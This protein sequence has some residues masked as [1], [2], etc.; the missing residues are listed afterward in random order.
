[1]EVKHIKVPSPLHTPVL[2]HSSLDGPSDPSGDLKR[3]SGMTNL[4]LKA[5]RNVQV[6]K[7]DRTSQ[8]EED[9]DNDK[10]K[11]EEGGGEGEGEKE[12]VDNCCSSS[13]I[14]QTA[15]DTDTQILDIDFMPQGEGEGEIEYGREVPSLSASHSSS[16]T[17]QPLPSSSSSS[18]STSTS[19]S[20]SDELQSDFAR[21][22][23]IRGKEV[24]SCTR[25]ITGNSPVACDTNY[26][27]AGGSDGAV[28]A[29]I[30]G[31]SATRD[32]ADTVGVEE[33]QKYVSAVHNISLSGVVQGALVSDGDVSEIDYMTPFTPPTRLKGSIAAGDNVMPLPL[34]GVST[35]LVPVPSA[36]T[37]IITDGSSG[38]TDVGTIKS[39]SGVEKVS[40][41]G[42]SSSTSGSCEGHHVKAVARIS[43]LGWGEHYDAWIDADS[44]LLSK[45]NSRSEGRRGDG[46][47]REEV[48]FLVRIRA[49]AAAAATGAELK[50]ECGSGSAANGKVS[51]YRFSTADSEEQGCFHSSDLADVVNAFGDGQG[52]ESLLTCM[53]SAAITEW[54]SAGEECKA[55]P[56]TPISVSSPLT[57]SIVTAIGG[58][59]RILSPQFLLYLDH[60]GFF[61]DA[62]AA[63]RNMSL[64][65]LRETPV[66]TVEVALD[67][68]ERLSTALSYVPPLLSSSTPS[69]T[70]SLDLAALLYDTAVRYLDCPYLNRRL[71]GLKML[72]DLFK[73]AQSSAA[74]PSGISVTRSTI[75]GGEE[76]VSYR[77]LPLLQHHTVRTLSQ[78]VAASSL[79]SSIFR[80]ERSHES[81]M[82][83]SWDILR[84]LIQEKCF[85]NP[86]LTTIW[87]AGFQQRETA[88]MTSLT[89]I[90]SVMGDTSI[91]SL[92]HSM[93]QVEPAA[94]TTHVVDVLSSMAMRC[95]SLVMAIPPMAATTDLTV[96]EFDCESA[97]GTGY[98]HTEVTGEAAETLDLHNR[99][100]HRLWAWAE[101]CSGVSD[102]AAVKCLSILVSAISLGTSFDLACADSAFPWN[103]QWSRSRALV[104][105]ALQSL[106][107]K[108]SVVPAVRLLQAFV[109]SLPVRGDF[110][111][112]CPLFEN[113]GVP[114][115]SPTRA[116][117]AEYLEATHG[118]VAAITSTICSFK[119]SFNNSVKSIA[120]DANGTVAGPGSSVPNS[121]VHSE[122]F[123]EELQAVLND[124]MVCGSRVGYKEQ[125]MRSLDFLHQFLRCSDS[126]V[127]G[128]DVVQSLWT[129]VASRAVTTEEVNLMVSFLTRL[130]LR[131]TSTSTSTS[132]P[133]IATLLPSELNTASSRISSL[134][135]PSCLPCT[136]MGDTGTSLPLPPLLPI[137]SAPPVPRRKAV[138]SLEVITW[139]FAELLCDKS[140]I[141]SP[142]FT[143][144]AFTCIEKYFKWLNTE[145]GLIVEAKTNT[146]TIVGPPSSLI[147]ISVFSDIII[148]SRWDPVASQAATLLTSL[149]S[150]L[151]PSLVDAGE[152]VSLRKLLLEQCTGQLAQA[153]LSGIEPRALSRL[154][155]LLS[156]LLDESC[157]DL[158]GRVQ[159]H[160]SLGQGA[161]VSLFIS[162]ANKMKELSGP[163]L[164]HAN[165]PLDGLFQEIC[166]RVNRPLCRLKVFRLA[167]DITLLDAQ[168][169]LGQ[170]KFGLNGTEQIMVTERAVA[171]AAVAPL[172]LLLPLTLPVAL[173]HDLIGESA[174]DVSATEDGVNTLIMSSDARTPVCT[175]TTASVSAGVPPS[176]SAILPTNSE[177]NVPVEMVV[178][179]VKELRVDM[180]PAMMLSS[181]PEHLDMMFALLEKSE[182][183]QV[184]EIWS[185]ISRLPS[186][187]ALM[188]SWQQL[189]THS[190]K[191]L[192]S[193]LS[194]PTSAR[195]QARAG[196]EGPSA[197]CV[198]R[199]LY[200]LQIIEAF[201]QPGGAATIIS[202]SSQDSCPADQKKNSEDQRFAPSALC[203]YDYLNRKLGH[204]WPALFLSKGGVE[205]ICSVYTSLSTFMAKMHS[206]QLTDSGLIRLG[207]SPGLVLQ[208][209]EVAVRLMRSVIVRGTVAAAVPDTNNAATT[210]ATIG[211]KGCNNS[212]S[213]SSNKRKLL[214]HMLRSFQAMRKVAPSTGPIPVAPTS[215]SSNN[216]PFVGPLPLPP[217]TSSS[218]SS[219][220]IYPSKAAD[221]NTV[222]IPAHTTSD[223]EE[224]TRCALSVPSFSLV[225]EELMDADKD[226]AECS[227][228]LSIEW[229][230]AMSSAT[231]TSS[232]ES[233]AASPVHLLAQF[234]QGVD[235]DIIQ[236]TSLSLMVSLRSFSN[237]MAFQE[238]SA[239]WVEKSTV[240]V[241]RRT[242]FTVLDSLFAVWA[243]AAVNKPEILLHLQATSYTPS[244]SSSATSASIFSE[245]SDASDMSL[246]LQL[247]LSQFL[248][249]VKS[250][251][252]D[253]SEMGDIIA[254]WGSEE[255]QIFIALISLLQPNNI[256][257]KSI[258]GLSASLKSNLFVSFLSL[259]PRLIA[260]ISS[261]SSSSYSTSSSSAVFSSSAV[262]ASEICVKELFSLASVLLGGPRGGSPSPISFLTPSTALPPC[263]YTF[264]GDMTVSFS[265]EERVQIS[266]DLMSEL[267]AA[268]A[269][270]RAAPFNIQLSPSGQQ[271]RVRREYVGDTLRVLYGLV[272]GYCAA[273]GIRG[274]GSLEVLKVMYEDR[275][276]VRFLLDDCLGLVSVS[277]ALALPAL[278][279]D[280]VSRIS[281]YALIMTL[282][283]W[284]PSIVFEV[285]RRLKSVHESVPP[286]SVWGFKPERDTRSVTGFMGLRN[287]GCT[288]YMNSLLQVL[289]MTPE[290]REGIISAQ[291]NP[292]SSEAAANDD[293]VLQLQRLFCNLK[294]GEKKAFSP[295]SWVFAYKDESGVLPVNVSQQQDAQEFF[296]VLCE[297]LSAHQGCK[298]PSSSSRNNSNNSSSDRGTGSSSNDISSG[299]VSGAIGDLLKR[300]F[301]GKIC[302]QMLKDSGTDIDTDTDTETRHDCNVDS[303]SGINNSNTNSNRKSNKNVREQE[304]P[305]VC[306]SLQVKGTKGLEHSLSQFVEGEQITDYQWEDSE[307]RV[308]ISKRQ[309]ISQ[310]SDTLVFHL[311]RFELN[312]DTF[313][314]EKVNDFFPFPTYLNML[315]YTKEGLMSPGLDKG[316][317]STYYQYELA[318]V[319][320]HTGTT[321]SGHYYAYIKDK[322]EEKS[323]SN[324]FVDSVPLPSSHSPLHS[325]ITLPGYASSS[326]SAQSA[327]SSNTKSS[328]CSGEKE[329]KTDRRGHR[330]LEFNDSEVS[331]FSESR[332]EAECF[333]GSTKSYNYSVSTINEVDTVNPKSAYMLV[334]RR[335]SLLSVPHS[336]VPSSS[337]STSPSSSSPTATSAPVTSEYNGADS[338]NNG[339][340][341]KCHTGIE[342][343][344]AGHS[345]HDQTDGSVSAVVRRIREENARHTMLIRLV[346]GVH[347]DC[348]STLLSLAMNYPPS[349]PTLPL[350]LPLAP[351]S[352]LAPTDLTTGRR[353]GGVGG[354]G[355]LPLDLVEDL[356]SLNMDLIT[357]SSYSDVA[358]RTF[359]TLSTSLSNSLGALSLF[360]ARIDDCIRKKND[361]GTEMAMT[362]CLDKDGDD[363]TDDDTDSDESAVA[364]NLLDDVSPEELHSVHSQST[365]V[366][367]VSGG[368]TASD[369]RTDTA[370][371]IM[372]VVV[373]VPTDEEAPHEIVGGLE[374]RLAKK[375]RL[376]DLTVSEKEGESDREG[377]VEVEDEVGR[378]DPVYL[379]VMKDTPN[380][381]RLIQTLA[382]TVAQRVAR[383]DGF[384]AVI[385]LLYCPDLETRMSFARF[386]L[387]A[388]HLFCLADRSR[389]SAGN[390]SVGFFMER[391]EVYEDILNV[392]FAL[393]SFPASSPA[394]VAGLSMTSH[395]T[396]IQMET[397]TDIA[398][399]S[400]DRLDSSSEDDE[401]AQAIK[402]SMEGCVVLIDDGDL[403]SY[404][405]RDRNRD[406]EE[407]KDRDSDRD[408]DGDE[409]FIPL[410][411]VAVP[412]PMD[413][414]GGYSLFT[415]QD[416]G[417]Q[418]DE[419]MC[420]IIVEMLYGGIDSDSDQLPVAAA[421]TGDLSFQA[422]PLTQSSIGDSTQPR[423]AADGGAGAMD[424]VDAARGDDG[425]Q[426]EMKGDRPTEYNVSDLPL[427][428]SF[429]IELTRDI[430]MQL[431]AENWRKSEAMTWLL[432]EIIRLEE[433]G[434]SVV[435][436]HRLFLMKRQT[437]SQLVAVFTGDN[438]LVKASDVQSSRKIAPSSFIL[439]GPSS[440]KG[441]PPPA[442]TRNIPDWTQLLEC[443]ALLV[444]SCRVEGGPNSLHPPPYS[445]LSLLPLDCTS[446][447]SATSR[448][449]YSIALKQSRYSAPVTSLILHLSEESV[450][451]SDMISEV[452]LETLFQ[453]SAETTA[454]IFTIMESFLTIQDSLVSHRAL[455]MFSGD[456]SPLTML[457]GIQDQGPK[458]R[459]VCVCIR[460]LM[461]LLQRVVSV[462][463]TLTQ[464]SSTLQTWAPWMLK[465]SFLFMNNCL[466][467]SNNAAALKS[468]YFDSSSSSSSG[469]SSSSLGND[470][471][472]GSSVPAE[473]GK[474]FYLFF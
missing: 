25:D 299:S 368:V 267:H 444:C 152:L 116:S 98:A 429:L 195:A 406:I 125:L 258:P 399:S 242:F 105:C 270:C 56:T 51:A 286:L 31:H 454:H 207:R 470:I 473:K 12:I 177:G 140:F 279:T 265:P 410:V 27:K 113:R 132:S 94:V 324:I 360:R 359:D 14:A 396:Q 350:L 228:L 29:S 66:E 108:K 387:E 134:Q 326:S 356:L 82:L 294:Y 141:T 250:G 269:A 154:L 388:F 118:L 401:I 278:C 223:V 407:D 317:S 253:K 58:L 200:N 123:S 296:Q 213:S 199:L 448:S 393:T 234:L 39:S 129:N 352:A 186:S 196:G 308:T 175:I 9:K 264:I 161:E 176:V 138:C 57:L 188:I 440:S 206:E 379:P 297:R 26:G 232:P 23:G 173:S 345:Y 227:Q 280:D 274:E 102:Q 322:G 247:F 462:R 130:V 355:E 121:S 474:E 450:S 174:S 370:L 40:S 449:L 99:V 158:D 438:S 156:G 277:S 18:T 101:D 276:I 398:A 426:G 425:D 282:C 436:G 313:R 341:G 74:N 241:R 445:S 238:S 303:N 391:A 369:V 381:L 260:P 321:D 136:V 24:V 211:S 36:D 288:C 114:F 235:M 72:T 432:L 378:G 55:A 315:P 428:V 159:P 254:K 403:D 109:C 435:Q 467:E 431:I 464:P 229:G 437:V 256:L 246:S 75:F 162:G 292:H 390:G 325:G 146:F 203:G 13:Y 340:Q 217:P 70:S 180:L 106:T 93:E 366:K 272:E 466:K 44:H 382:A 110:R 218:F 344:E 262:L 107:E 329:K 418:G 312:F 147:G 115:P 411:A 337:S 80:G 122:I 423:S 21:S 301:G 183:V 63:V 86:M 394:S 43:Y 310:L 271:L 61:Q 168:R 15:S 314:R 208:C 374:D 339:F 187:P 377:E 239:D 181:S 336:N 19:F 41:R 346:D 184:D 323:S 133:T 281:A 165:D 112:V 451:F 78:Q 52:F 371:G 67:A 465:F 22:L 460:S 85:E 402:L 6:D 100:L 212:S 185:L 385:S 1:M 155:M 404:D 81:L 73:R 305:F 302:Y 126:L 383:K 28:I 143:P 37:S 178:E 343:P 48:I 60:R 190:V 179:K 216:G 148:S 347:L 65:E 348:I 97:Y 455:S 210:A 273:S 194:L 144:Q 259:R 249:G 373:V 96:M 214:L 430:R 380:S 268:S 160:G 225:A 309:C 231:C 34:S 459:L 145:A 3:K 472:A 358:R 357:H 198:A 193:S 157:Q 62:A 224:G 79:L 38:S 76:K 421:M 456:M 408:G 293:I 427:A 2:T 166:R 164:M 349:L 441:G 139:A 442:T 77:V 163:F 192:L 91:S 447:L 33:G 35:F 71:G 255:L 88:A 306:L 353:D 332:L 298:V 424:V 468:T 83:R 287:K 95:R 263:P 363:D 351:A 7:T 92:L 4:R 416:S 420:D 151:A 137:P 386:L 221:F 240:R 171:V 230:A 392:D 153:A 10:N 285:F 331:E 384:E 412:I 47:V 124:V 20:P 170:L 319:V 362:L 364:I 8:K 11:E 149:P 236:R 117:I 204:S 342:S 50:R 111:G 87:E 275:D 197:L 243:A 295:D 103:V 182:S 202:S 291:I 397:Q 395:P 327:T 205:A 376:V 458:K 304:D 222:P 471:T 189:E 400:C 414:E 128:Q 365:G 405:V 335:V 150:C 215:N 434:E 127:L 320:V 120:G 53:H 244:S 219:P 142:F 257:Q 328:G 289:Y 131:P 49:R 338:A 439:I 172:P 237:D 330:W 169:T 84:T 135:T 316:R 333:G 375:A 32:V 461:V 266:V 389:D 283:L 318:G 45:L 233:Q 191:D 419:D 453:C 463:E 443:V 311:K 433:L 16:P 59:H 69:S 367:R 446:A 5:D 415:S 30:N 17:P 209:L 119:E 64:K 307:P 248:L 409:V 46:P 261:S 245:T 469:A 68:I 422:L 167:K 226:D 104:M 457:K 89:D 417:V 334:Y 90:I 252:G 251:R 284:K 290:V 361:K 300:S 220:P 372:D 201:M 42:V 413:Q 54:R 452:L 354:G